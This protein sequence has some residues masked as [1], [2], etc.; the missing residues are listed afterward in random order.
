M[1]YTYH[2]NF[3]DQ[4]PLRQSFFDLALDTFSINFKP[5]FEKGYW[6][7]D[8]QPHG[9][10]LG[11]KMVSNASVNH[12]SL[13]INQKKISAI[14]IGTVM[15]H[16]DHRKLG[17]AKKLMEKILEDYQASNSFFYLF[18]DNEAQKF[19]EKLGFQVYKETDYSTDYD[20]KSQRA[21]LRKLDM[22][23]EE[24]HYTFDVISKQQILFKGDFEM[25][26]KSTL[27]GFYGYMIYRDHLYLEESSKTIYIFVD[28]GQDL[29]VIDII[30]S[31]ALSLEYHL[32]KLV[33]YKQKVHFHFKPEP[34][35]SK[36][37]KK[38]LDSDGPLMIYGLNIDLPSDFRF[39]AT[40]QA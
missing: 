19:Y 30:Q 39:K 10:F 1:D 3:K 33:H 28:K 17:L 21:P 25:V 18:A 38:P 23:L 15:T 16:K 22:T 32:Q 12:M 36:V 27:S 35:R 13:L 34:I 9:W 7:S 24:D 14:Q 6:T 5:W 37:E 20:S 8:Y 29:E 2:T 26:Q 4:A 40:N 31:Q 11:D